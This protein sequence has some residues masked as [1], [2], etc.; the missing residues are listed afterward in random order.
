MCRSIE[1]GGR[2]CTCTPA[3]RR[4]QRLATRLGGDPATRARVAA[5]P[6][7]YRSGTISDRAEYVGGCHDAAVLEAAIRDSSSVRRAAAGAPGLTGRQQQGL[8]SHPDRHTRAA[9]AG[10]PNLDVDVLVGLAWDRADTVRVAVAGNAR[11]PAGSLHGLRTDPAPAV[12]AAARANDAARRHAPA[13]PAV[14]SE[15]MEAITLSADP[16]F[17]EIVGRLAAKEERVERR[18]SAREAR[19]EVAAAP[20]GE[21]IAAVRA[22]Q[23][24]LD[25][26]PWL[27]ARAA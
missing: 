15:L 17:R 5:L 4:Q 1:E 13:A 8:A 25:Y 21:W 12:A 10:N 7:A 24:E 26:A 23:T 11:L 27:A 2:R 3:A 14:A 16:G 9:L 18:A 6:D 22:G 20:L 19:D